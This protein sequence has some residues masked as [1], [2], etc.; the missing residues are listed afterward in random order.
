MIHIKEI[1]FGNKAQTRDGE[2]VTVQQI[3]SNS[4]V[5]EVQ[6]E[7]AMEVV[8]SVR[9][10]AGDSMLE[11]MEEI[12]EF[13]CR[14]LYPIPLSLEILKKCGFRNFTREEWIISIGNSH[15]DFVF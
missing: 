4:I 6:V 13:D 8:H 14:E 10:F 9:T 1:R 15:I 7:A 5:C 3:L 12:K 11:L 2:I